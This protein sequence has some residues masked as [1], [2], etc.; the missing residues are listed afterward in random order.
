MFSQIVAKEILQQLG[1]NRFIVMTGSKKF[2]ADE[3]ALTMHLTKN[4]AGAKYLRIELRHD[5]TYNMIFRK[6]DKKNFTFPIVEKIEGVYC[7]QLQEIFT[8]VTG[9][10]TRL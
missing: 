3:A 4:K 8:R 5:D 2:A 1:G 7:D 6:D 10:Y 9:L